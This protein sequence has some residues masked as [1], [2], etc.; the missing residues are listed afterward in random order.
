M[1]F[2]IYHKETVAVLTTRSIPRPFEIGELAKAAEFRFW[3][4]VLTLQAPV[5]AVLW[6]LLLARSMHL[7]LNPFEPWALALAVWLI[8]VADHLIDTAQPVRSAWE[9]PRKDFCRRHWGTFLAIAVVV[10]FLLAACVSRLLW[11]ATV[12]GGCQLL[13]GVAGYFTLIHVMPSHWRRDWPREIAVAVLFTVGTFGAVFLANGQQAKPLLA[14][15][16]L[17]MLLCWANCSLIETWEWQ[18]TGSPAAEAPNRLARWAAEHVISVSA[19]LAVMSGLL[20]L[21]SFLPAEF[22]LALCLSG[23]LLSLLSICRRAVPVRLVSP[24]ADL[25]LCAPLVLLL[26]LWFTPAK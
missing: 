13:L 1:P 26:F 3:P 20:R 17:F 8:Y 22:A 10:A 7:R 25:A 18:A 5:V 9:P 16:L 21:A 11:V 15:S 24:A 23:A 2:D 12:R 4:N 19:L 6:Q 14:P